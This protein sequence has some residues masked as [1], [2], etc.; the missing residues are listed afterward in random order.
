MTNEQLFE[1]YRRWHKIA[2][3]FSLG[4]LAGGVLTALAVSED[5]EGFIFG[6]LAVVLFLISLGGGLYWEGKMD[7]LK[8]YDAE[9]V[10]K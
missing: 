8:A 5:D 3:A 4:I 2:Y 9:E 7:G 6:V 1:R 10:Q